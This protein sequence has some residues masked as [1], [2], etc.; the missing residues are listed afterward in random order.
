MVFWEFFIDTYP[1]FVHID[2]G[3]VIWFK[4]YTRNLRLVMRILG[5]LVT[6]LTY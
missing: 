3:D 4:I 5:I 6:I 1:M 2:H